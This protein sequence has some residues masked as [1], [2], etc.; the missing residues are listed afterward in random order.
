MKGYWTQFAQVGTPNQAF[1]PAPF[2]PLFTITSPA[3]LSLDD[4]RPHASLSFSAEH[5]CT[6]W[7]VLL[8]QGVLETVLNG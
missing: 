4:P 6:F 5:H 7:S 1:S 2:W 8:I 3:M